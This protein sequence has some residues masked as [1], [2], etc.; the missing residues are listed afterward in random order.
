MVG[1]AKVRRMDTG[2]VGYV[3]FNDKNQVRKYPC[4]VCSEKFHSLASLQKHREQHNSARME[5]NKSAIAKGVIKPNV[6]EMMLSGRV[7]SGNSTPSTPAK[8]LSYNKKSKGA[9]SDNLL[10]YCGMCGIYFSSAGKLEL[11][12]SMKH[13]PAISAPVP[14]QFPCDLCDLKFNKIDALITHRST[15]V[16]AQDVDENKCHL[17]DREN[18]SAQAFKIHI[19][20]NHI[21]QD[22]SRSHVCKVCAQGF[23]S[24]AD[25]VEH[26]K[27]M[28]RLG[29]YRTQTT[30]CKIGGGILVGGGADGIYKSLPTPE[31]EVP[32]KV[33]DTV[34]I[35]EGGCYVEETNDIRL[36]I[37][38]FHGGGGA[39]PPFHQ[40]PIVYQTQTQT[41][42]LPTLG[43][44]PMKQAVQVGGQMVQT[45]QIGQPN[46]YGQPNQLGQMNQRGQIGQQVNHIGQTSIMRTAKT[47]SE[48]TP[49]QRQNISKTLR[50]LKALKA[51][52]AKT[53][54]AAAAK[55]PNQTPATTPRAFQALQTLKAKANAGVRPGGPVTQH[56]KPT[57]TAQN[58]QAVVET[59]EVEDSGPE[60]P[61]TPSLKTISVTQPIQTAD[62]P[63]HTVEATETAEPT[64]PTAV[65][66]ILATGAGPAAQSLVGQQVQ[67]NKPQGLA[68]LKGKPV[69][70][71]MQGPGGKL[72]LVPYT[73]KGTVSPPATTS[74][75][76]ITVPVT[77][78]ESA[79][80]EDKGLNMPILL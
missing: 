20:E 4:N 60:E 68:G 37:S 17:C 61:E 2:E 33:N 47:S 62:E 46:L 38:Q 56:S 51:A 27:K 7:G 58:F 49:Q 11:H 67:A 1:A 76:T 6:I 35:R 59:I 24:L 69:R 79:A 41:Q 14:D 50:A 71:L 57:F 26:D 13:T 23:S 29:L 18:E 9:A 28:H 66:T 39:P 36:E 21:I 16:Q 65:P 44:S 32:V 40:T 55:N 80:T 8:M 25:L 75:Q 42:A 34:T 52:G 63:T 3:P 15:H 45:I 5:S 30:D 48:Q 43:L 31:N 22:S 72:L 73:P 70:R 19:A 10:S 74:V 12:N 78:F 54:A 53:A 77:T 64:Q